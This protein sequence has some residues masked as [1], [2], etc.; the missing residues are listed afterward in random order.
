MDVPRGTSAEGHNFTKLCMLSRTIVRRGPTNQAVTPSDPPRE[1]V[2]IVLLGL[3]IA[4]LARY[5]AA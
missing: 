3:R 1:V 4:V 5:E 2:S